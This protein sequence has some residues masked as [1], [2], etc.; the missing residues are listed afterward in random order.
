MLWNVEISSI[1]ANTF[2]CC[3]KKH[4]DFTRVIQGGPWSFKSAHIILQKWVDDKAYEEIPFDRLA[5]WIQVHNFPLDR[6]NA[7][8]AETIEDFAGEYLYMDN[9]GVQNLKLTRYIRIRTAIDT[10]K[11][12]KNKFF[13]AKGKFQPN[14][15]PVQI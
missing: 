4:E 2:P 9:S 8:N 13:L 3:F 15:D 12:L 14:L 6:M 5:L 7:Q 10:T 1:E 11:P